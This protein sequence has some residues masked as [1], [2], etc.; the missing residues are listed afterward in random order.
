M[1]RTGSLETPP[2]ILSGDVLGW[3]AGK[4]TS[5]AVLDAFVARGGG[6]IDGRSLFGAGDGLTPPA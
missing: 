3:T 4:A 2:L 6:M 1:R 5:F